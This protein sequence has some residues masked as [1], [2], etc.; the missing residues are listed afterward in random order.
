MAAC[1]PLVSIILTSYNYA[2]F[3]G[4]TIESVLTQSYSQWQLVIVDDCSV[5]NSWDVISSYTDPRIHSVR[6][7]QNRGAA[8]AY[9]VAY[10]M[11]KGEYIACV[12]SDDWFD[13]EKLAAQATYLIANPE[14]AV[15]G[16]F[17]HEVDSDGV[18]LGVAGKVEDWFNQPLDLNQPE[19][20]IWRNH[21]CHSSVVIRK[22]L[23]DVIGLPDKDLTYTPDWSLWLRCLV[24]G[25][26]FHV[27]PEKLTY[28]RA[29]AGNITKKNLAQTFWEY[30]YTSSKTLHPWLIKTAKSDLVLQNISGFL[31][32]ALYAQ[33]NVHEHVALAGAL[34]H[35]FE[36]MFQDQY[37]KRNESQVAHEIEAVVL[38]AYGQ[39][40][41][42]FHQLWAANNEL[43]VQH[44][45]LEE[46]HSQL[47]EQHSQLEEQHSQLEEQHSQLEEQH[48]QLE[49]RHQRLR[50]RHSQLVAETSRLGYRAV[51]RARNILQSRLPWAYIVLSRLLMF[52]LLIWRFRPVKKY[53]QIRSKLQ[54]KRETILN[55][56]WPVDS[57]LISVVIPCFNY[58]KYLI[59]AIDSVLAQ[60]F[61][62]FEIIVVD[63]ESTDAH[64][65]EILASL[66][67]PKTRIIRQKNQR[68]S[69][70]RNN[71]I[72][73][74]RGKYICCLD[75]DDLIAPTYLEKCIYILETKQL[76]I[77]YSWVQLFEEDTFLWKCGPFLIDELLLGNPVSTSAVFRKSAWE[78]TN[79]YSRDLRHGYED[80][81]FWIR[82]AKLGA[83]GHLIPEPLF[84]YRKHGISLTTATDLIHSKLCD[85]I[86]VLHEDIY[87]DGKIL[88]KIRRQQFK[89]DYVVRD[90]LCNLQR[91]NIGPAGINS[92]VTSK[93]QRQVRSE[94]PHPTLMIAIPFMVIGGAERLLSEMTGYL[95]RHGWRVI[96]V[97]TNHQDDSHGDSTDWFQQHTSEVYA[98]PR[99]LEPDKWQDFVEYLLISRRPDC[100]LTAGSQLFYDCLPILSERN[101]DMAIV[102][103]LFNTSGHVIS[104]L[105]KKSFYTFAFAE[106]DKV[107]T[108]YGSIGWEENKLRKLSSGVD[109]NSYQPKPKPVDLTNL[110]GITPADIVVGFSGRLSPE[111][112]PEVFIEI[113]QLCQ[114][115]P[116]LR[117]MMTGGGTMTDE[118]RNLV[119]DLPSNVR[120]DF[121]GLV[122]DVTPYLAL[123]DILILPSR[124]DGRPLVVLEGLACGLPIIASRIGGLPEVIVDD[125]NGYL[126]APAV[127]AEFAAHISTL[128]MD[129]PRVERLKVGA[130]TFAEKHLDAEVNFAFYETS[131][132]DAISYRRSQLRA[133]FGLAMQH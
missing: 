72:H 97:A 13:P 61:Q 132:R 113:A 22:A 11:C 42:Q 40:K 12:D 38:T 76:D 67:K 95:V 17:I 124:L 78:K 37:Q 47:E 59:E 116:N 107:I 9:A 36:G 101:P 26:N 54:F 90:P 118:I 98:L 53:L 6:L 94:I 89:Q 69:M 77:C 111:K 25:A 71:G 100:L 4:K 20:W 74:A 73:E 86:K 119:S 34:L 121:V 130:R 39:L 44:S 10:K 133:G 127:A 50:D 96:V 105:K 21:L 31:E 122:N 63:D 109:L 8:T 82:I 125:Y 64:T 29:H 88:A 123:Y 92:A 46:Q 91:L 103:L 81:E 112:A 128:A 45:Q 115:V 120:F 56:S 93:P 80:W 48:S 27:I 83:R 52:S 19:N 79:G 65:L 117:F 57:P 75:A 99:F 28:Y 126:C 41:V 16:T 33:L 85:Q 43:E 66:N 15:C 108:W 106:S 60:T 35:D 7:V 102:D 5:D 129:R 3:I 23:H 84:L 30:A 1:N 49:E 55:D 70:A 131:F 24:L 114:G 62:D 87:S 2:G 58:G 51:N 110:Y 104:H 68:V 18:T 14:V 32:H